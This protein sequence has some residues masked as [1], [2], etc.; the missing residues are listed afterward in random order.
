MAT[1][2]E[3]D[4]KLFVDSIRTYLKVTTRQEP[5]ITSAFL[6]TEDLEGFEFNGI[7]TF[8]GS[9][10]GHVVVSMPARLVREI[11]LLQHETDLR[12]SNLLDAVGEIANTLAGNA[13]KSL[14]SELDI[15]VPVKVQG[16][17]GIKA[18]VRKHPYVI[19]LRWNHYEAMVCVDMD[20]RH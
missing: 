12:D 18:R 4:L 20:R 10:N 1:L 6:G 13:R 14:G 8:S 9:H 3:T 2:N 16:L 7:V 15:S 5:Q 17:N 19:T 11:L